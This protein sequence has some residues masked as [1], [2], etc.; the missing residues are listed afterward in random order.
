MDEIA[1]NWTIVTG[2]AMLLG[3]LF[4][5]VF[6]ALAKKWPAFEPV[7]AYKKHVVFLVA[8]G[9]A[10]YFTAQSAIIPPLDLNDPASYSGFGILLAGYA[11]SAFKV[12]EKIYDVVGKDVLEA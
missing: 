10:M 4:N 12:A 6:K 9:L 1:V 3:F 7:L 8:L 5:Q 11:T 2:A